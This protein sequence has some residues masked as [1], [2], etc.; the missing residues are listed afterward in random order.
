[1]LSSITRCRI[2][3]GVRKDDREGRG[4]F[5]I[6]T[7]A[8]S[9]AGIFNSGANTQ[10]LCTSRLLSEGLMRKFSVD[11]YFAVKRPLYFSHAV[12]ECL[13]GVV[14][15]HLGDCTYSDNGFETTSQKNF[16]EQPPDLSN[17]EDEKAIAWFEASNGRLSES[18]DSALGDRGI[19]TKRQ[20]YCDENEYR[21]AWTLKHVADSLKLV[22]CK[23]AVRYCSR[24]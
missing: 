19:F 24:R 3:E 1:M 17:A 2:I 16:L 9:V 14:S 18:I 8:H 22:S 6:A 20:S 10:I 4:N 7:R 15:T 23:E 13:A 11:D 12:S 5:Y 21:F